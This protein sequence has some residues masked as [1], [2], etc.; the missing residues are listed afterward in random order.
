M[1]QREIVTRG[2]L[3]EGYMAAKTDDA[4]TRK[5]L[6]KEVEK[7]LA[8]R[9][10]PLLS[11]ILQMMKIFE[12]DNHS[13]NIK[14][15][16]EMAVPIFEYLDTL[17]EYERID[18]EILSRVICYHADFG[19]T[20][21]LFNKFLDILNERCAIDPSYN[22]IRI[23]LHYN[24]TNRILRAKFID[25]DVDEE[26]LEE[27]FTKC[28]DLVM[29]VCKQKNKLPQMYTL[30]I[31][32][33]LFHQNISTV[34][35]G[36]EK[37]QK[38]KDRDRTNAARYEISDYLPHIEGDFG[39]GLRRI[40]I[41]Q[42]IT[43]CYKELGLKRGELASKLHISYARLSRILYGL[44]SI[45]ADILL[46]AAD[47]FGVSTGYLLGDEETAEKEADADVFML[48][49]RAKI[50]GATAIEKAAVLEAVDFT[51]NVMRKK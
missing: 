16:Y 2:M 31:R 27:A 36:L 17:D 51:L 34:Q 14:K 44:E 8:F 23:S 19:K 40:V 20:Y 12:L 39:V 21:E 9:I 45:T 32:F 11:A 29:K 47:I 10:D 7:Y 15:C 18:L 3:V 5:Y 38:T 35:D 26:L 37:L 48:N 28:Y 43:K 49:I 13:N 50:H 25:E 33:G 46:T 41:G 22:G 1:G 24:L 4:L 42:R 6:V 30:E